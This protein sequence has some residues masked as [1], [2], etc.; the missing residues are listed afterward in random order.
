VRVK[1]G[2]YVRARH[3]YRAPPPPDGGRR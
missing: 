3:S 2:W 1:D